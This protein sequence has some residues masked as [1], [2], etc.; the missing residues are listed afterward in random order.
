MPLGKGLNKITM[1]HR[2]FEQIHKD[3]KILGGLLSAIVVN[4]GNGSGVTVFQFT[5]GDGGSLT[6]IAGSTDYINPVLAADGS[7]YVVHLN[8]QGFLDKD[9]DYSTSAGQFTLLNGAQFDDASKWTII[10]I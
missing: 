9:V 3:L 2:W 10:I 8:G 5:I 1:D 4:T 7:N 6:P